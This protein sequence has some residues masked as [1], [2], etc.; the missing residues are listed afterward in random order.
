[1]TFPCTVGFLGESRY[2][3]GMLSRMFLLFASLGAYDGGSAF[4]QRPRR[5]YGDGVA[6]LVLSHDCWL[7]FYKVLL[8]GD[9]SFLFFFF[10]FFLSRGNVC[11]RPP[12]RVL[13]LSTVYGGFTPSR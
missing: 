10:P 7:R 11:A 9:F 1:M 13:M 2:G 3:V 4:S 6:W 12:R 8:H 5:R